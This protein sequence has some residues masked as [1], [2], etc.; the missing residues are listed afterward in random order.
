MIT[1]PIDE[2]SKLTSLGVFTGK[3]SL[4]Y[5]LSKL[6]IF[7]ITLG[8]G[9][10]S[11][12]LAAALAQ[13]KTIFRISHPLVHS[14]PNDFNGIIQQTFLGSLFFDCSSSP[15]ERIY[16]DPIVFL[17]L[18][19]YYSN[20]S[21]FDK[22]KK[23]LK[24]FGIV[25][26][27]LKHFISTVRHLL[28]RAYDYD[29]HLRSELVLEGT[30]EKYFVAPKNGK[31]S[32]ADQWEEHI[33]IP[34]DVIN[35][36]KLVLLWSFHN[37]LIQSKFKEEHGYRKKE[38]PATKKIENESN[39]SVLEMK[40]TMFPSIQDFLKYFKISKKLFH[41]ENDFK[42][43]NKNGEIGENEDND[44]EEEGKEGKTTVP[45]KGLND[46]N[47]SKRDNNFQPNDVES[48]FQLEITGKYLY[49]FPFLVCGNAMTANYIFEQFFQCIFKYYH[50]ELK[51]Y[52]QDQANPHSEKKKVT[53]Y[54]H[55]HNCAADL[56]KA[57]YLHR[58]QFLAVL[59]FEKLTMNKYKKEN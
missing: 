19:L 45:K 2:L 3:S 26:S 58:L 22:Q 49:E 44:E 38:K 18:F 29:N 35:K 41:R 15:M 59:Y 36:L 51:N 57:T 55:A 32:D 16:S 14:N 52:S 48:L 24:D 31:Q 33:C 9:V 23:F 11:I 8:V 37:N 20:L 21:S 6:M 30:I 50:M 56:E 4:D 34:P 39:K 53:N 46:H 28:G 17:K 10:E 12:I 5:N 47:H 1:S 43:K 7:G 25:F 27:R 40:T 13:P 42:Q 54:F